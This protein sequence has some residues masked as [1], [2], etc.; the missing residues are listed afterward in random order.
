MSV[1]YSNYISASITHIAPPTLPNTRVIILPPVST[2]GGQQIIVRDATGTAGSNAMSVI[3]QGLDLFDGVT[4]TF[5]INQNYQ[6]L[7]CMPYGSTIW[8]VT[9]TYTPLYF[10]K[11][12]L[13]LVGGTGGNSISS[14]LYSTDGSNWYTCNYGFPNSWGD[15]TGVAVGSGKF[16]VA[17]TSSS[18]YYTATGGSSWTEIIGAQLRN[19]AYDGSNYWAGVSN[20]VYYVD[21]NLSF[22]SN[23]SGT[24]FGGSNGYGIAYGNGFWIAVGDGGG[25]PVTSIL[26]SVSAIPNFFNQINSGGFNGV[27]RGIAYDGSNLWVATGYDSNSY[28]GTLQYSGDATNWSNATSGGF[29]TFGIVG[30]GDVGPPYTGQAIAYDG[31]NLWVAVGQGTTTT[32]SIKYSGDAF[33]WSDIASGGFSNTL[34]FS[35]VYN[36]FGIAYNGS[37]LW[38]ATGA[39]DGIT[40][41]TTI[42]YSGDSSNWSNTNAGGFSNPPGAPPSLAYG[43]GFG[44][45][46]NGS[47]LW[48]SVGSG[49]SLTPTTTIQYS[50]DGSNWSNANSGG[51]PNPAFPPGS[52]GQGR[53]IAYNGSNLWVAV[54]QGDGTSPSTSILYSGD[55]SNWSDA[56]SGG[57]PATQTTGFGIAY[58]GSNLWVAAGQGDFTS[59][60]TTL[61][62]SGDGSN[63]SD[64]NTGGFF[65]SAGYCVAFSTNLWVAG[66][67][68]QGGNTSSC[69]LYSSDGSNWSDSISGG[70]FNTQANGVA[71]GNSYWVATGSGD[72]NQNSI[73]LSSDGSNWSNITGGGFGFLDG[74]LSNMPSTGFGVAYGNGL[75]VA[76]GADASAQG[77]LKY[78]TD[79]SNWLNAASGGFDTSVGFGVTYSNNIFLAFGSNSSNRNNTIL[80]SGDGSNW[81][82]SITGGFE[83][84]AFSGAFRK[85]LGPLSN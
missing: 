25:N 18:P 16:L 29:S 31:S 84:A 51:F 20:Y 77:S 34:G 56:N 1:T 78:S 74:T 32:N 58:N 55:G 44:V 82:N 68:G 49:D 12:P 47:N 13:W 8:S 66:G 70:F 71:F 40:T 26:K 54:G 60:S 75:W 52:A 45:A 81:S 30:G 65:N 19:I 27:G 38:I 14:L 22:W 73:I 83:G 46:Y 62:Y 23:A 5:M 36:G 17:N 76:T 57:F 67:D 72:S 59:P 85:L 2:I 6:T 35:G 11:S 33:N 79:G 64:A 41:T 43:A 10:K 3:T 61:L 15:T 80:Y 21:S 7:T 28:L 9:N 4:N 63:W 24:N 69:L 53:G 48:V 39:G 42:K 37:N 50:G